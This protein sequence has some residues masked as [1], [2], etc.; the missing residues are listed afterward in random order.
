MD[1]VAERGR[2]LG[3]STEPVSGRRGQWGPRV[4]IVEDEP[5][6]REALAE[7]LE[8]KHF[9]V[10]GQAGDGAEAVRLAS[11]LQPDVVLMDLRMPGID[12]IQATKQIKEIL[13]RTQ[14]LVLSAYD[15]PGLHR[16]AEQAGVFCYLVKGCAP[17]LILEMIERAWSHAKAP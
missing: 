4:L 15:D 10:A 8:T 9:R 5:A 7:M 11:T 2:E 12:G 13:P 1:A 16:S 17:Q 14:V 6:L 3:P